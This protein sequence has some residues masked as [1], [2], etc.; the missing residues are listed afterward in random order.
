MSRLTHREREAEGWP[1]QGLRLTG[2]GD[3]ASAGGAPRERDRQEGILW[4]VAGRG[5]SGLSA[6][7]GAGTGAGERW[8][9]LTSLAP[10]P[11]AA[12]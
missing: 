2:R 11:R 9:P 3:V 6:R 5:G 8:L 1:S 12:G 7:S 4:R 10:Q